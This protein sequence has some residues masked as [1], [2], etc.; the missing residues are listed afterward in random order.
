[1]VVKFLKIKEGFL[2]ATR[3]KTFNIDFNNGAHCIETAESPAVCPI[4]LM[5]LKGMT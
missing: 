2:L 1:M 4:S 3:P 5:C